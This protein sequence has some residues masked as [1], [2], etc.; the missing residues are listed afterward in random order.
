MPGTDLNLSGSLDGSTWRFRK[1]RSTGLWGLRRVRWLCSLKPQVSRLFS[2]WCLWSM[3][4]WMCAWSGYLGHHGSRRPGHKKIHKSGRN[5]LQHHA[6][7]RAFSR[8]H[9]WMDATKIL[10]QTQRPRW[11]TA[12]GHNPVAAV[13]KFIKFRPLPTTQGQKLWIC[14]ATCAGRTAALEERPAMRKDER[15]CFD[16]SHQKFKCLSYLFILG[17][18]ARCLLW[19]YIVWRHW[20]HF[21]IVKTGVDMPL[22][23][24]PFTQS[25][26]HRCSR[27]HLQLQPRTSW[28]A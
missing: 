14:L 10:V 26:V 27:P 25:Q 19:P 9:W 4:F 1:S 5:S 13:M 2:R 28:A 12:Y 20:F 11:F 17:R 8:L 16:V 22:R 6:E 23:W 21:S 24:S 3:F 18:F 7:N 15:T